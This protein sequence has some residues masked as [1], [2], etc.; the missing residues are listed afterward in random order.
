LILYQ[1]FGFV[2]S[3]FAVVRP[4]LVLGF[5]ISTPFVRG[6]LMSFHLF[7]FLFDPEKPLKGITLDAQIVK[8]LETYKKNGKAISKSVFEK[9]TEGMS[10][11]EKLTSMSLSELG[12]S[13]FGFEK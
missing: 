10:F 13:P 7:Y 9:N 12:F 5:F 2:W 11:T 6:L 4:A 1:V 3:V 8:Y